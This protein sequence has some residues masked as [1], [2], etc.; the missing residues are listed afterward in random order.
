MRIKTPKPMKFLYYIV[1][2]LL[3]VVSLFPLW[4][5][6]RLSDGLY[7]LLYY[8]IRYRRPLVRK[9]LT[10]SF[11]EKSEAETV[12][13]EKAFYAWFC[14]YIVESVKLYSIGKREMS[15]RMRFEGVEWVRQTVAKGQS[16]AVYLG[17]YCNWEWITSLPLALY[18]DDIVCAQIYHVL[19]NPAFDQLFLRLRNR[20]GAVSIPMA[21]TIRRIFQFRNEGKKVVIGFIADQAPFWNNIHYWTDFLRHDTPVFTGTER[22]ARKGDFAVYYLDVHREKRGYYVAEFKLLTEAPASLP[23]YGVT[24][25]YIRALENTIRRQPQY[26]L[27]SHNRWKR[28]REEWLKVVDPVTHKMRL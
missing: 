23:E 26:W 14:D 11:P 10:E 21:E 15:R 25:L 6:Y 13:I 7:L 1:S 9:N 8:L 24:E 16:V 28:T 2:A 3:Y 22:I 5:L 19:E 17:H 4:L 20:F 27:W 12:K 18:G